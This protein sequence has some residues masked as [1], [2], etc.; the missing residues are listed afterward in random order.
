MRFDTRLIASA[1]AVCGGKRK[2]R[3]EIEKRYEAIEEILDDHP[4]IKKL[5]YKT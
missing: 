3:H 2:Y 1:L 5:V 4:K